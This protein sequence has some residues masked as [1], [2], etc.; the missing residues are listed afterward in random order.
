MTAATQ[1]SRPR[2]TESSGAS[3]AREVSTRRTSPNGPRDTQYG[4]RSWASSEAAA[5]PA[6][7]RAQKSSAAHKLSC[8]RCIRSKSATCLP[9]LA[10]F[11]DQAITFE[12]RSV[13]VDY[14]RRSEGLALCG[15][16]AA[17]AW[18]LVVLAASALTYVA[19]AIAL[20]GSV[21]I[22]LRFWPLLVTQFASSFINRVSPAN[23]GGMAL[24]ARF[25]QKSGAEPAAGVTAVGVNA[26]AGAVVHLALIAIF[27]TL[28]RRRLS[29]A[30]KLPSPS[31]VLL[32]L[33]I[34][35]AVVGVILAVRRAR[36]FAARMILP[37]VRSSLANLR[38]VAR[39]PAKLALLV[40][41]SALVTLAYIGGVVA[42]VEA[43]GGRSVSLRSARAS[44]PRRRSPRCPAHRA[45]WV[46]S[47]PR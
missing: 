26:L 23:V 45:A 40:G 36:R 21:A 22:R 38:E 30:F 6:G 2:G 35:A 15:R 7:C 12:A 25:L 24:N 44:W 47:R 39:H 4:N 17:W 8:S 31:K 5:T 16:G 19:S 43:F 34:I 3:S 37:Q 42:S 27:F 13:L 11:V 32:V 28:A 1:S 10:I 29:G 9:S 41:G 20:A 46:P 14:V 33:A 18:L